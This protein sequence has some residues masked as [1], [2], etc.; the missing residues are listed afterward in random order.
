[1]KFLILFLISFNVFANYIPKNKVGDCSMGLTVYMKASKCVGDCIKIPKNYNCNYHE[2]V[3]ETQ[4]KEDVESCVDEAECQ[5]IMASKEC[6]TSY[7]EKVYT[8]DPNEVY[9]TYT[10]PEMVMENASLKDAHKTA[11]QA[12]KDAKKAKKDAAKAAKAKKWKNMSSKER[13]EL[14]EYL[15]RNL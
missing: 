13:D 12:E 4:M 5:S 6:S 8:L 7:A 11:K 9:C 1:M 10:R 3:A 15:V 2:V 14:I